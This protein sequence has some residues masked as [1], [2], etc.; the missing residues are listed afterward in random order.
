MDPKSCPHPHSLFLTDNFHILP[1][2]P[3]LPNGPLTFR[4]SNILYVFLISHMHDAW[5]VHLILCDPVNW[6]FG[7]YANIKLM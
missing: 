7:Y 4:L 1:H 2:T 3:G 6:L 5:P